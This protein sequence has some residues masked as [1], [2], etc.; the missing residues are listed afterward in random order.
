MKIGHMTI[1]IQLWSSWSNHISYS[2]SSQLT[3]KRSAIRP[4]F[5]RSISGVGSRIAVAP[6]RLAQ[7]IGRDLRFCGGLAQSDLRRGFAAP[8]GSDSLEGN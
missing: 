3:L 7:W 1:A 8:G 6:K 5:R 2:A 4:G